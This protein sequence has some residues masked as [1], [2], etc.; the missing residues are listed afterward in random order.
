VICIL[1]GHCLGLAIDLSLCADIRLCT[2]S[3]RFAVKEVDIGI[4]ADIGT[5][6]RLPKAVGSASWVKEVCL[7]AREWGAEE[8]R[9]EGFVSGVLA[10]KEAAVR[11]GERICALVGGKSPVAVLG[12]KELL[13]YGRGR[14]VED[15]LGYTAVWNAAMLQTEDV[16]VA[17]GKRGR[18]FERL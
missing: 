9:R 4:A 7:T 12:T 14:T 10:D 5:L 1:H 8:A 13:N 15:G 17:V 6:T 18:G 11:E 3:A 2:A 16:G